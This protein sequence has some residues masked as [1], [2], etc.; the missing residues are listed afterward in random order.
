[1]GMGEPIQLVW[2]KRDL[3]TQDNDALALAGQVGAVIPLYVFEPAL[4]QQSDASAR[5]LE[6][7]I[8]SVQALRHELA[9][10]G[11]PLLVRVGPILQ[12]LQ[13]LTASHR[14]DAIWSHQETG[15]AWTFARD[16]AVAA[17]LRAR[18][19][20]WHQPRPFGIVRG[21]RLR[22]GWAA[23]WER[24]VCAAPAAAAVL[25]AP[26]GL[27]P[28]RI[29]T[30][31]QLGMAPDP[32]PQRQRGGRN[33]GLAALAG[34][35]TID[36]RGARY[37]R[38]MSSP[39]T[40]TRACSRISPHLAFGSISLREVVAASR[41]T[42]ERL[43]DVPGASSAVQQRALVAF[44]SRLHWHCHFMQ[45]LET[46]PALEFEPVHPGYRG[47]RPAHSDPARL[48]GWAAGQT[49]WPF[50]DACMRM[51][52]AGGW[53][54]FRMRAMLIAVASYHL[55]LPWR[56]T[57]L[58]L[59]R[60][61]T[62][63]EPGI[64]WPQVQMQSG[65]TGINIPR[66]YNPIKQ[67]QD[68]DP[69]GAFIRRWIPELARVPATWIHQPWKM[70]LAMQRSFGCVIGSDYPEPLCDHEHA[71]RWARAQITAWRRRPGMFEHN[72]AVLV[73]HGSR[74][75]KLDGVARVSTPRAAAAQDDMFPAN[76][77]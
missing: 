69:D 4:W 14:I 3:R 5:Q 29:P 37:H 39:R 28:G 19:I 25:R 44:E 54:N 43:A 61:F 49:G 23:Q 9:A 66:I 52:D 77:P 18:A 36:G 8:E 17:W 42:R 46:E 13:Q 10:L 56:D 59:A 73:R 2:F 7:A 65:V 31:A 62:D 16:R 75:R 21:L 55:W 45:K 6:F 58:V 47:M 26:A 22:R 38:E 32:C 27:E 11:M 50:V 24:F 1:M 12:V 57:G 30:S 70:P 53:I 51:L 60:R 20:A 74:R 35:T 72:H 63:Y 67:S 40:A 48:A 71:A 64:H 76:L 34:F 15:N 41:A 68:Q 33:R